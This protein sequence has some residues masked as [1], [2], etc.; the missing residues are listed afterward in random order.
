MSA[1]KMKAERPIT[2]S[3]T[4]PNVTRTSAS[5][6][7]LLTIRVLATLGLCIAAYLSLLHYRAGTS[8]VIES[9]LCSISSTISCNAVLGSSY[10]RLFGIPVATWAA[11]TYALTLG[12]SFLGSSSLLI[13]LCCWTFAFSVYMAGLS[14]LAI[15]AAC[16]FCMSLYAIN[17]GSLIGAVALAR[18]S[19]VFTV[20]QV[21]YSL[22]GCAVL[23]AGVG[24][25]QTQNVAAYTPKTQ[26]EAKLVDWYNHL[27]L[28]TVTAAERHV[29]GS[30]QAL[31]TISEFVDFRCPACAR[32]RESLKKIVD[33][34][35]TDIKL[36]FH[37][38]PLDNE[39]NPNVPRAVHPASCLASF[40]A[41]CAGEQGNF[42]EYANRLFS[43]Q[44]EYTRPDLETYA[45]FIGLDID[46]FNTCMNEGRSKEVVRKDIDSAQQI[47]VNS[48]PTLVVNGRRIEGLPRP[49]QFQTIVEIE[50]RRATAKK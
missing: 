42:W 48:T 19:G 13:L 26:D 18:S 27:P 34:H 11:L 1:K 15:K 41:E 36:V 17:T 38:Y 49:E 43:D 33:E 6:W 47:G 14:L 32:A 2:A 23:A 4:T 44:K 5:R 12:V 45:G 3:M 50:K 46:R 22:A 37:H 31:I 40:A 39:C 24:W 20:P 29:K 30:P 35:P 8:G 25:W 21:I 10:A 28:V 7:P 9:P 16:L